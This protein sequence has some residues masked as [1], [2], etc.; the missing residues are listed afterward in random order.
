MGRK[1]GREGD[2][3]QRGTGGRAGSAETLQTELAAPSPSAKWTIHNSES[4]AKKRE[5]SEALQR[6]RAESEGVSVSLGGRRGRRSAGRR[7]LWSFQE[8]KE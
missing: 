2:V 8:L 5:R 3:G 4:A 6:L 7:P 1:R